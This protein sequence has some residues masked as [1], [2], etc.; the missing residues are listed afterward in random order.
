MELSAIELAVQL[1]D[2]ILVDVRRVEEWQATGVIT[3]AYR[4]TFFDELGQ[5]DPAGWLA[6]L[7]QF[8]RPED[9][10]V[11]ICRSG[12]RTGMILEFLHRHTDYKQA[13][14]LAGGML[15][16]LNAGLP[17]ERVSD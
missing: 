9:D 16:W 14:H 1:S 3:G 5:A 2:K 12:K 7:A 4:L 8:A 17:V 13:R 10:L 11:L 6:K 15:G